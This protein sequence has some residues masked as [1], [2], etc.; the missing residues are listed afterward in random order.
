MLK[1]L[2]LRSCL[3]SIIILNFSNM[4]TMGLKDI[5]TSES[6]KIFCATTALLA[7]VELCSLIA[8]CEMKRD[9]LAYKNLPYN[10]IV[11]SQ[12]QFA[13]TENLIVSLIAAASAH[14][15]PLRPFKIKYLILPLGIAAAYSIHR[16]KKHKIE[17][18]IGNG[19]AG[20]TRFQSPDIQ[21]KI[22]LLQGIT[23]FSDYFHLTLFL[24]GLS[25]LAIGASY[26]GIT[27]TFCLLR[28]FINVK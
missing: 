20:I 4:H 23:V 3:A 1:K 15:S 22:R 21:K 28:D 18:I 11:L 24:A 9:G 14:L 2:F 17:N 27:K 7:G 10:E 13:I 25:H 19:N 16:A 5:A 6:A 8:E 12:A 26:F